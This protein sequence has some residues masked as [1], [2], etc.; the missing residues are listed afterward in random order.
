MDSRAGPRAN[1]LRFGK[2]RELAS[3]W[4]EPLAVDTKQQAGPALPQNGRLVADYFAL[5]AVF[6]FGGKC[7]FNQCSMLAL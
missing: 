2:N 4:K 6:F 5:A 7:W 1:W 3:L